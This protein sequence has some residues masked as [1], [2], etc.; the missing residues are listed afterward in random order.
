MLIHCSKK[1]I[2]LEV[3]DGRLVQKNKEFNKII[4]NL[5]PRRL[6]E[7][8]SSQ[9]L[10]LIFFQNLHAPLGDCPGPKD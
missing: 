4:Y 2:H 3:M 1:L 10:L 9:K 6:F 5:C 8:Q 7:P